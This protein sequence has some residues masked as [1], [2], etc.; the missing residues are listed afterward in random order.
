MM[1]DCISS[2]QYSALGQMLSSGLLLSTMPRNVIV[3]S[4]CIVHV[5]HLLYLA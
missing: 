4:Y 5:T 3:Y 2:S 1:T